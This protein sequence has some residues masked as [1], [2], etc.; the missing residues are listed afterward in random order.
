MASKR[1]PIQPFSGRKFAARYGLDPLHPDFWA[2]EQFLY[3][4]DGLIL[5]DDPPIFEPPDPPGPTLEQRLASIE[6]R[7][8]AVESKLPAVA[9]GVRP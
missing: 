4:R 5:P 1:F 3:L 8:T 2:D 9:I 6:A 7:L